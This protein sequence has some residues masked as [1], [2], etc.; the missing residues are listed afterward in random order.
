MSSPDPAR[1]RPRTPGTFVVARV[2]G[3][4]IE[5]NASWLLML[6]VLAFLMSDVVLNVQPDLGAWSYAVGALFGV[7]LYVT[8][9]LHEISHAV[10]ARGFGMPVRAINLQFFGGV[11]EIE[12]EA[13]TPMREFVIAV[14]GPLTSLALGGLAYVMRDVSGVPL[15]DLTVVWLA[16]T[17]LAVGVL[18]LVPGLPLDGGRVAQAGVWAVTKD[19]LLGV[20]VA[21]WGGRAAAVLVLCAPILLSRFDHVVTLWDW[22]VAGLMASFLWAGA[23]QALT[24]AR[25]RRRFPAL[26]ARELA[27]PAIGVPSDLPV[28]EAIRRAQ[29]TRAGAVVVVDSY[30]RPTGIVSEDAV[31]A[32]PAER[33][34]WVATSTV[35]RSVDDGLLLSVDLEGESLVRAMTGTP[36][37]EYVLVDDAGRI[38]GVLVARDVDEAF[39]RA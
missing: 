22:V 36:A 17:N 39:R 34:P 5:V 12:G 33:Q 15:V 32:M 9:L 16:I 10:A 6:A 27:R 21:A 11:T 29:E 38:F 26:R 23:T 3:I 7:L 13:T 28:G 8:V 30:G 14:V 4:D 2:R 37:S 1:Q 25:M 31:A 24:L 35:A 20:T 18:N 19:R